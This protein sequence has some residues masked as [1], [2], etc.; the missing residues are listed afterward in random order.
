MTKPKGIIVSNQILLLLWIK[1]K[2]TNFLLFKCWA[3]WLKQ[4]RIPLQC[5]RLGF[6][7]WVEKI[8]WR[9]A[10][11]PTLVFL[12]GESPWTGRLQ[13]MELQIRIWLRQSTAHG[14]FSPSR[15]REALPV[16]AAQ[17]FSY[18]GWCCPCKKYTVQCQV[19]HR[20]DWLKVSKTYFHWWAT[21]TTF[22]R[23]AKP[24]PLKQSS[25]KKNDIPRMWGLVC[26]QRPWSKMQFPCGYILAW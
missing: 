26:H 20:F 6:D 25:Q 12:P 19:A 17:A 15:Q 18:W 16:F 24:Q 23:E 5:R 8:P 10:W 14:R 21:P 7:P 3:W 2:L 4:W 1:S 22:R 9:R 11:Q 13:S